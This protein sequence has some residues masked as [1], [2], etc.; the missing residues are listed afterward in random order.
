MLALPCTISCAVPAATVGPTSPAPGGGGDAHVEAAHGGEAGGS[1][2]TSDPGPDTARPAA[3]AS[4]HPGINDNY[5]KETKI[6][7]W[8][9]RF[10]I[11]GTGRRACRDGCDWPYRF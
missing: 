1:E 4:V 8:R 7:R 6:P 2:A 9:R 5:F 10:A 3:E 11:R